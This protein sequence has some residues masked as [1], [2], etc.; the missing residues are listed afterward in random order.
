M[1]HQRN[2]VTRYRIS[3]TCSMEPSIRF[4]SSNWTTFTSCT[5]QQNY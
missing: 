2:Q 1:D 4:K 3:S 5:M